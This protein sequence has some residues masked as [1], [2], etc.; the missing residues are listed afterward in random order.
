MWTKPVIS[1]DIGTYDTKIVVGKQ[2][3]KNIVVED[4]YR[5]PTP[6]GACE[7]GYLNN[8]EALKKS[9]GDF[10]AKQKIKEKKVICTIQSM[11]TITR[12]II[13]PFVKSSEELG[14][15]VRLEVEQYLPILLEDYVVEHKVLEEFVE[16]G[17]KK[18]RIF[19]AILPK[20][21]V[22]EYLQLIYDLNLKP[23][24]LDIHNNAVSKVF[25]E[26]VKINEENDSLDKTV[27]TIDMG[28]ANMNVSILDRG[29][30]RFN[31]IIPQG[32]KDIDINVA[33]A[34]NLS[35]EDAE[36]KKIQ[37]GNLKLSLGE[38]SPTA[39]LNELIKAT[40]N[41]WLQEIQRIFQYYTSRSNLYRIDEIY[42]YG[43]SS[44]IPY[45]PEYM[46]EAL[47]LPTVLLENI[48]NIKC[49]EEMILSEYFN[50]AAAMMR[51]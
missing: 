45:L 21:I 9:I 36:R 51:K 35:V 17:V 7:D 39:M 46:T 49:P 40:V 29:V 27:V 1:M 37:H 23:M 20:K 33:N 47:Q 19:V 48:S 44:K 42:L 26:A 5:I 4:A 6:S 13:L 41:N 28:Y 2:Q 10:L 11:D 12:E 25:D 14:S 31:R 30:L 8:K 3:K 38:T 43:G 32:G 22:E 16:E 24:A 34:F 15:M 18:L 50:A